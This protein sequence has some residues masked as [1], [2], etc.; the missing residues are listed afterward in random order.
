MV[1]ASLQ[2]MA[3][4]SLPAEVQADIPVRSTV[5]I[6]Q[7]PAAEGLPPK[8]RAIDAGLRTEVIAGGADLVISAL[9]DEDVARHLRDGG[10]DPDW[11]SEP[12]K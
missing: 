3:S 2:Q 11:R 1:S 10:H 5:E 6:T 9:R 7:Q 8:M 4:A 12:D